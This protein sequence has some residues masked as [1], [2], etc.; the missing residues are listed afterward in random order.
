MLPTGLIHAC[1]TELGH[2]ALAAF[3]CRQ[4]RAVTRIAIY[5]FSAQDSCCAHLNS[6]LCLPL[7][8]CLRSEGERSSCPESR[9]NGFAVGERGELGRGS[10]FT[11]VPHG[12][13]LHRYS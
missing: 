12:P 7:L 9:I 10:I 11:A 13:A 1:A 8:I 4:R 6:S 2:N 5:D 3:L